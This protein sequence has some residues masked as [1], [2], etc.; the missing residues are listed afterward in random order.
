MPRLPHLSGQEVVRALAK[1]GFEA[2]RQRGSHQ[3]MRRGSTVCVVPLHKEVK[4]GT[5]AGLLRQAQVTPD[6]FIEAATE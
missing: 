6:E 3:V 4:I 2:V 1:L 5:L